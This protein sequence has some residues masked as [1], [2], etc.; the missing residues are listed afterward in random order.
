MF[1]GALGKGQ[2]SFVA[3]PS[4]G[5]EDRLKAALRTETPARLLHPK[6]IAHIVNDGF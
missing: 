5:S 1:A 6:R 4:G 2:W 3:P